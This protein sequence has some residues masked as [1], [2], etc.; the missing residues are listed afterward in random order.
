MAGRI[1]NRSECAEIFGV[2]AGTIS[3][4]VDAGMPSVS[5]PTTRGQEWSFNTKAVSDWLQE[6]AVRSVIGDPANADTAELRRR[7][8]AAE[9]E[10]AEMEA[11]RLGRSLI[12]VDWAVEIFGGDLDVIKAKL[13]TIPVRAAP[14]VVGQTNLGVVQR[15][16]RKLVEEIKAEV[17]NYRHALEQ[18]MDKEEGKK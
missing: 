9:A 18:R 5:R 4:W 16:L 1:V 6:R 15:S 2:R 12:P 11:D 8:L 14:L 3:K 13:E 17:R 7:K 10:M